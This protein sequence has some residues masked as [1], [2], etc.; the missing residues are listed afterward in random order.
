MRRR[1]IPLLASRGHKITALVREGSFAPPQATKIVAN[2]LVRGSYTA[3][4]PRLD[5]FIHLIGTPP[6]E[7]GKGK[8]VSRS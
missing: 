8:T 3:G 4:I 7:S 1:L 5:T 6:P 2:P